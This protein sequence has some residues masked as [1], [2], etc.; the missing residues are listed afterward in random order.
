MEL[1]PC[2]PLRDR[3]VTD[4]GDWCARFSGKPGTV[5]PKA[6]A[7]PEDALDAPEDDA[8]AEPTTEPDPAPEAPTQR[9]RR[10]GSDASE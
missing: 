7:P 9:R 8:P 1:K 6:P 2:H 5:A 10:R 3:E 4:F